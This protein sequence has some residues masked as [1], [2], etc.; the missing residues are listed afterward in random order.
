MRHLISR[1]CFRTY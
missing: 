1:Y